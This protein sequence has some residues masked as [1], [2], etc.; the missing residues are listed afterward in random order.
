M[1]DNNDFYPNLRRKKLYI[2]RTPSRTSLLLFILILPFSIISKGQE[3]KS[4]KAKEIKPY[5]AQEISPAGSSEIKKEEKGESDSKPNGTYADVS[6]FFSLYQYYVPGAS[7]TVPDYTNNREVLHNSAGTGV[8]PGSIKI[9][10]NGTYIW[11]SSWDGKILKG[12][13]RLTGDADYPIEL[14]R[15]Q[16]GK[17]WKVG[18]SKEKNVSIVVWDGNTW[19]NGSKLKGNNNN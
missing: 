13:W 8:L 2:M 18:K 10:A 4:Y 17:N 9:S 14:L 16:K 3:I 12:H 15:A 19:Y 7:Y 6:Y 11:N 5:K 1:S